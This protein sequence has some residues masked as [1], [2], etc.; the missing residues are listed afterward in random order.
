MLHG[1]ACSDGQDPVVQWLWAEP[2]HE[3]VA[4]ELVNKTGRTEEIGGIVC[5]GRAALPGGDDVSRA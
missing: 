4:V 5:A 1:G 3:V 2:A